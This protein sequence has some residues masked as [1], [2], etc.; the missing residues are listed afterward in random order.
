MRIPGAHWS[1]EPRGW[2]GPR[3]PAQE[4]R[5]PS[6]PGEFLLRGGRG[7]ARFDEIRRSASRD[8]SRRRR[9][10]AGDT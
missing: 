5:D 6:L 3:G 1:V 8:V 9:A 10:L 2:G 4:R 7:S